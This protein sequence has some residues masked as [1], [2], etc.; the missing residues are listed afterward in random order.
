MSK[1][2]LLTRKEAAK[3]LR[4]SVRSVD[5]YRQQKRLGD[6]PYGEYRMMIPEDAV[7]A[8][9]Q[10]CIEMGYQRQRRSASY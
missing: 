7:T 2:V 5:R 3:R 4:V 8:F 6:Q 9:E 1:H 10:D